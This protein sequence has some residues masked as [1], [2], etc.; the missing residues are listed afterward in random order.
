M[1]IVRVANIFTFEMAH[2]LWN[3][4]GQCHNVHGHSYK[5]IVTFIGQPVN[6]K[7][8]SQEGMLIDFSDLKSIVDKRIVSAF[9]HALVLYS[10][11]DENII[12]TLNNTF[13]KIVL[14]PFQPT[15]ENLIH[16]F[17]EILKNE[18]I[19]N[20]AL[21]SL[22]LYETATSYCDWHASDNT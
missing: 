10:K 22:R 16:H 12:N 11:T 15:C 9:D 6:E 3:Y 14:L 7:N 17:A 2:A 20:A 8:H 4:K 18:T 21:H 13:D 19:N 1:P 5:L